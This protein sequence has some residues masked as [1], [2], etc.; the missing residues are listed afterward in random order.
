MRERH[1]AGPGV[2]GQEPRPGA[3]ARSGGSRPGR[4]CRGGALGES[5]AGD[6][7]LQHNGAAFGGEVA[8]WFNARLESVS[9]LYPTGSSISPS[10]PAFP[11]PSLRR[12]PPRPAHTT[13]SHMRQSFHSTAPAAGSAGGRR[14]S[15]ASRNARATRALTDRALPA[16]P[17]RESRRWQTLLHA[18]HRRRVFPPVSRIGR[19]QPAQNVRSQCVQKWVAGRLRWA[20]Q[21]GRPS[22]VIA[23]PVGSG[24]ESSGM[25]PPAGQ[26]PGT[27][28][29]RA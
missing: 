11:H 25:H 1:L 20:W 4:A 6:P 16:T 14:K 27:A 21:A 28:R 29:H 23:G 7:R 10:P 5:V 9:G 8:E 24:A 13:L 3:T 2:I 22:A 12:S 26:P 17:S 15:K 19:R 18:G